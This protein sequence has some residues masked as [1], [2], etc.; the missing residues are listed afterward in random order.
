MKITWLGHS[1]FRL[2]QGKT[3]VLIDPFLSGNSKFACSV[4]E[5]SA[6]VT[7]ILLSEGINDIAFPGARLGG[8]VLADPAE[9]PTV[10]DLIGA[11][12]QLIAR[13]HARGTQVIGATGPGPDADQW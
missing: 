10:D 2:E 9:A 13:A 11:Y 6:G 3:V 12:R 1:A 5:A 7:H 8:R 4:E